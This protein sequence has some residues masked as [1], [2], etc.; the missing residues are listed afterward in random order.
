VTTADSACDNADPADLFYWQWDPNTAAT[1]GVT[2]TSGV[3][4]QTHRYPASGSGTTPAVIAVV[5]RRG[6]DCVAARSVQVDVQGCGGCPT[7][8][9]V[10]VVAD[11]PCTADRQRRT[12]TLGATINGSAVDSYIWDFGDGTSATLPGAGGPQTT[13]AY[14]PGTYTVTLTATG[15]APCTTQRSATV[16]VDACCPEVA[17]LTVTPGTCPPGAAVRPVALTA[18]VAGTGVTSY[19]WSFGDGTPDA[20]TSG[21]AAPSHNYSPGSYAAT[22][23][24]TTPGCPD[25]TFT[26]TVTV[27]GCPPVG[28]GGG[29]GGGSISCAVLLWIAM[30]LILAGCILAVLGCILSNTFPQAGLILLIIGAA[31]FVLG[32]LLFGLWLLIC[33]SFTACSVILAVRD[34][35]I[36][37]IFVFAVAAAVLAA[38]ALFGITFLWP[39]AAAAAA[40][41]LNWGAI[42]AI[43]DKV[44]QARGCL[45][46]NPSGGT[47]GASSSA[48]FQS[49]GSE[50][51][52]RS[53]GDVSDAG[54]S[55]VVGQPRDRVGAASALAPAMA[56]STASGPGVA[57]SSSRPQGLGDVIKGVTTA[58]GIAPCAPCQARAEQLNRLMP[59]TAPATEDD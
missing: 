30:F 33:S 3:S 47:S 39:C 50:S 59:L 28:G 43:L 17:A 2:G 37:L 11:P 7:I 40:A 46:V 13:H 9:S 31:L 54:R 32:W 24:A 55:S 45:I 14:P 44:A 20:T 49:A 15:P 34:F 26:S 51:T 58:M 48:G 23:R 16:T 27:A 25:S 10:D 12:V 22:V 36:A 42:L 35:V 38:L 41:G 56:A 19:T 8:T 18:T 53:A 21:P 52:V 6:A 57:P 29:G 5:V 1:V 4:T